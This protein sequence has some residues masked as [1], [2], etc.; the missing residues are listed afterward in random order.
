MEVDP[1]KM[2]EERLYK[3][4]MGC[5]VPRPIA[6]VSTVDQNGI[7]NIAPFSFFTGLSHRPPILGVS[8]GG[9]TRKKDTLT[10]IESTGELVVN[11]VTRNLAEAMNKTAVNC[12]PEINEFDFA[13]IKSRP[14]VKV[15]PLR[16]AET[17]IAMECRSLEI[18]PVPKSTYHLV[19]AEVIYFHIDDRAVVG[20]EI[21]IH[22]LKPISRLSGNW[23]SEADDLFEMVRPMWPGKKR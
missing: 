14:S 3:L 2:D 20:D 23:Y 13:Q 22:E 18:K 8:I 12:P 6:W 5:V 4:F 10:N 1:L 21:K 7:M 15:K 11:V 9:G 17:P 19:I 16:V